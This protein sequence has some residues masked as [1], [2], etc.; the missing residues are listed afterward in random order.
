MDSDN[1]H[2]LPS[3]GQ[4]QTF[5]LPSRDHPKHH[6]ALRSG[7]VLGHGTEHFHRPKSPKRDMLPQP[8]VSDDE[9]WQQ[10]RNETRFAFNRSKET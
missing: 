4:E 2:K 8:F 3:S 10:L 9:A 6:A 1:S 7:Q 5:V